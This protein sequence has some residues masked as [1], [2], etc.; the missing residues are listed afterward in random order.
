M[1]TSLGR[2]QAKTN[3]IFV[4]KLC[5]YL[6]PGADISYTGSRTAR[7]SKYL[8]TALA[9]PEIVSENLAEEVALGRIAGPFFHSTIPQLASVSHR[10]CA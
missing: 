5:S 3:H 7:F 4:T 10:S 1:T 2:R 6:K 8:P 9:Q